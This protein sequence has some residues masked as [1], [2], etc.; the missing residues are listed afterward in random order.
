[1]PHANQTSMVT[2]AFRVVEADGH[3]CV[4]RDGAISWTFAD[5]GS[6]VG[7]AISLAQQLASCALG[8]SISVTLPSLRRPEGE[9]LHFGALTTRAA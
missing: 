1:M 7:Y 8:E 3:W 9:V 6:A 2:I 4:E 5:R